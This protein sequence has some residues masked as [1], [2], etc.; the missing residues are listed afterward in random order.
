MDAAGSTVSTRCASAVVA[1]LT[2][3]VA[4]TALA[5][6]DN[7][8]GSARTIENAKYVV[9]FRTTPDP[10]VV[11]THFVLDFAVCARGMAKPPRSVRVDA[12]MPEHRHGMNYRPVVTARGS[13]SYHA[14]GLMFH[15]PG[16]W[17]LLFDVVTSAGS[18][19]LT[20]TLQIE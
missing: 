1:L 16:R 19:R 15:M 6:G 11:G 5:C 2:L 13:G 10:V 8:G 7:L 14:E 4:S 12:R 9:A 17:D 3:L 18:E 20:G